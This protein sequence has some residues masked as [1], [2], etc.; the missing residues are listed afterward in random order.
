MG[1]RFSG[2][3]GRWKVSIQQSVEWREASYERG[4]GS[5]ED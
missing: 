4:G 1:T 2:N 3:N 5:G